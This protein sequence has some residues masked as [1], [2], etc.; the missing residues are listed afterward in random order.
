MPPGIKPLPK[1]ILT[2]IFVW[3]IGEFHGPDSY[4]NTNKFDIHYWSSGWNVIY[5]MMSIADLY[6]S[7][8]VFVQNITCQISIW[9]GWYTL[10][11][12]VPQLSD[13]ECA[14]LKCNMMTSSNG[15]IFRVTGPLCG[16]F[17]V[18]GEF[19]TQKPV[20]RSFD[21]YF[22]LRLN[23]RLSKRPWGWWFETPSWSLWRQCNEITV[24]IGSWFPQPVL[25]GPRVVLDRPGNNF[26]MPIRTDGTFVQLYSSDH[27]TI[28]SMA[29]QSCC[30]GMCKTLPIGR[31]EIK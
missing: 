2:Q 27:W 31:L 4:R 9:C 18:P 8:L 21:V 15:N 10:Q 1:P 28:L 29:P 20:T 19:P 7:F 25:I 13:K 12:T 14:G 5:R 30:S 24:I 17:T 23:K 11:W 26:S 3:W 16:E 6:I 22:D